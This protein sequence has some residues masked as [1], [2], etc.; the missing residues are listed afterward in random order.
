MSSPQ[1]LP[2]QLHLYFWLPLRWFIGSI[3]HI[4]N[5]SSNRLSFLLFAFSP[6]YALA[7]FELRKDWEFCKTSSSG[8][9]CIT[10]SFSIYLFLLT[11]YYNSKEKPGYTF[12]ST[13][14]LEMS[15]AKCLSLLLTSSVFCPAVAYN[16]YKIGF[17]FIFLH[18]YNTDG[19]FSSV[20]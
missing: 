2:G 4:L 9:I 18:L 3:C 12:N 6:E 8:S 7:P 17:C 14:F 5:I 16:S 19:L 11:L 13:L 20:P 15:S 10:V 1:I